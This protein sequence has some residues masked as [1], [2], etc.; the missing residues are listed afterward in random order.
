MK[1]LQSI[2][3]TKDQNMSACEI[4]DMDA[5]LD[6]IDEFSQFIKT[7]DNLND[8]QLQEEL[9]LFKKYIKWKMEDFSEESYS[10]LIPSL[11]RNA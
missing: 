1:N 4:D 9:H 8:K 3:R 6:H 5:L 7:H 10:Y 2:K 11:K